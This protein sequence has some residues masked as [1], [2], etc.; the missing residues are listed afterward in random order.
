M[1]Q[2]FFRHVE[3]FVLEVL[4]TVPVF[5]AVAPIVVEFRRAFRIPVDDETFSGAVDFGTAL[6]GKNRRN[7][8]IAVAH[9][10]RFGLDIAPG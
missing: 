9:E 4:P 8:H 5:W 2:Q 3:A 7:T 10:A 6:G 1:C